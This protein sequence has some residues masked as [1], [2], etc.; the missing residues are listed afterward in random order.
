MHTL[1]LFPV[2]KPK[3]TLRNEVVILTSEGICLQPLL[4]ASC[5]LAQDQHFEIAMPYLP[6]D[7]KV[8][9]NISLFG[10]EVLGHIF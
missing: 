6:K 4:S 8:N 10:Q 9:K 2:Y 5:F 7:D 3:E 1:K